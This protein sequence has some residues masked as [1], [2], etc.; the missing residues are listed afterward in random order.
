MQPIITS[1]DFAFIP[2]VEEFV[3]AH[4]GTSKQYRHE[5][6]EFS[7]ISFSKCTVTLAPVANEVRARCDQ[8]Q[9][10]NV[11]DVVLAREFVY[12]VRV[13]IEMKLWDLLASDPSVMKDPT[14]DD[15]LGRI[16][17][18]RN[19]GER[20]FNEEPFR[21]LLELPQF[22]PGA[23]FRTVINKAHHGRADQ[24]SPVEADTVRIGYEDVFSAIDACWLAYARFMG[25]LPPEQAVA[26]VR[27]TAS[28][29]K[30]V[31]LPAKPI[32]VIGRLAARELGAALC[33]VDQA[34]EK[35]D[36][37]SLGD[38]SLFTLRAPT[39]GLVALPGQTLIVSTD[40]EVKNGDYAVVQTPGK[41]YARRIGLDKADPS[42]IALETMPSTNAGAPPTHFVQRASATLS[43]IIGVIF[44]DAKTTKSQDE[45]VPV[46]D[47]PIL[48]QVVA[49]AVVSGDSAFPVA[50]DKGHV[51]LGKAPDLSL[52]YGRILAVVTQTDSG[53]G[54]HFAYLKRLGKAM[55]GATS[56]HYLENVGQSGEG[57]F[58]QFASPDADPVKDVPIAQQYWKVLGS[59]FV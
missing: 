8:W 9:K 50:L 41:T 18:A 3:A 35:F 26:E 17:N 42:R 45:A 19:R 54:D 21:R 36:L 53:S 25:R 40:A 22:K 38:V 28:T 2:T 29:L 23:A 15:L 56:I 55:P 5:T 11:N 37:A 43:K 44:D 24:I 16:A 32:A 7:A 20:P 1:N 30:L 27:K 33:S 48:A 58:V 10:T 57:E 46:S 52:L 34:T 14:L 12:P 49:A 39:L 13:R 51:L 59:I 4:K 31:A 6:W 47:S